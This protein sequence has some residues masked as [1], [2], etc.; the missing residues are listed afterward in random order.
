MINVS[1]LQL[2]QAN[3]FDA[4]CQDIK[5]FALK[6]RQ[7][8][9]R[10]SCYVSSSVFLWLIVLLG[11]CGFGNRSVEATIQ[12]GYCVGRKRTIGRSE[13]AED[14]STATKDSGSCENFNGISFEEIGPQ[15]CH[16]QGK[17][18]CGSKAGPHSTGVSQIRVT[19][20]RGYGGLF[21]HDYVSEYADHLRTSIE[22][23]K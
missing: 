8:K 9:V 21:T 2:V 1:S 15:A 5:E 13:N 11:T 3:I 7:E 23:A 12:R 6:M 22:S 10:K 4:D 17:L 16:V 19:Y 14:Y 18:V 20:R